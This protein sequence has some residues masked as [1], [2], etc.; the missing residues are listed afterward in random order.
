MKYKMSFNIKVLQGKQNI[1]KMLSIIT[2]LNLLT[3]SSS[4]INETVHYWNGFIFNK[5]S[6]NM[7]V[8]ASIGGL[9]TLSGTA[10]CRWVTKQETG[11]MFWCLPANN[12]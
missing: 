4:F 6:Q 2:L 1:I 10:I 12:F 5:A 8:F 11:S 3:L 9:S 7:T